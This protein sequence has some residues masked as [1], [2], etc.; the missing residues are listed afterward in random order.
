MKNKASIQ[1][2]YLL[3]P[4]AKKKTVHERFDKGYLFWSISTEFVERIEFL[5][6][7]KKSRLGKIIYLFNV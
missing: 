5:N 2:R 6:F 7:R 1:K 4:K 3:N